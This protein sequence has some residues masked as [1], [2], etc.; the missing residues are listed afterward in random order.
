FSNFWVGTVIDNNGVFTYS[1]IPLTSGSGSVN[2]QIPAKARL[3]VVAVS[4]PASYSG[5]ET[6][7]YRI[8]I[9]RQ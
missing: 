4:T 7:S 6:F 1:T 8:K 5:L 3:Y 9:N 2:I